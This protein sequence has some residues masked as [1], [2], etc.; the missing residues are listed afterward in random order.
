VIF[1]NVATIA[2]AIAT[3]TVTVTVIAIVIAA[4]SMCIIWVVNALSPKKD[5]GE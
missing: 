2:I 1:V 4:Q 3:V 5:D